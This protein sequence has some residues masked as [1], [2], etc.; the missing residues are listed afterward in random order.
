[1]A[2]PIRSKRLQPLLRG[3]RKR[4]Q[5]MF[6]KLDEP[7]KSVFPY[8]QVHEIRQHNLVR[9]ANLVVEDGVP[10]AI[11]ECGVLDGGTAALMAWGSR[12]ARPP[13]EVHLFDAWE[14]LPETTR[15]LRSGP[16]R[17]SAA[18]TV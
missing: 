3:L 11:V 12:N 6:L 5:R 15:P 17:S 8:T 7:Y 18:P 9:L 1:V 16:E 2:A 14:G 13:R 10:G 4:Y